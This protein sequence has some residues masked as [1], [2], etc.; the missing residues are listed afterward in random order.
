MKDR[1]SIMRIMCGVPLKDTKISM[2]IILMLDLTEAKDQ[3]AIASSVRWFG[4][5]LRRE[6]GHVLRW[7]LSFE[8]QRKKREDEED[9]GKNIYL[10]FFLPIIKYFK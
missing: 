2:D 10:D 6:D 8:G 9:V 4:H 1:R 5:V 7:V 3:L